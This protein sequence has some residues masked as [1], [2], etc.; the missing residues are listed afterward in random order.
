MVE[1]ELF[2]LLVLVLSLLA[3]RGGRGYV[4]GWVGVQTVQVGEGEAGGTEVVVGV[5][6]RRGGGGQREVGLG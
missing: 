1:V 2:L 4:Q 3:V 6:E 5:G